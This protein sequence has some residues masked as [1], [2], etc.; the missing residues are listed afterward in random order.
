MYP[1]DVDISRYWVEFYDADGKIYNQLDLKVP[2]TFT[3]EYDGALA[4][5][6]FGHFGIDNA[7]MGPNGLALVDPSG[8]M[9]DFISYGA[10]VIVGT[11][12]SALNKVSNPIG[13]AETGDTSITMSVQLTG[14]GFDKKH[15]TWVGPGDSSPGSLNDNQSFTNCDVDSSLLSRP[16]TA[17]DILINQLPTRMPTPN[18][19]FGVSNTMHITCNIKYGSLHSELT[20]TKLLFFSYKKFNR[21]SYSSTKFITE[22]KE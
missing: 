13:V 7:E 22:T 9:L 1:A 8:K 12:G 5:A 19:D 15:F 4:I 16:T 20:R 17:P 14:T 11:D 6:S 2:A 3:T 18:C 21:I 10:G